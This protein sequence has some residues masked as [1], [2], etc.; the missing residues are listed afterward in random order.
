M[1]SKQEI[2]GNDVVTIIGAGVVV[3]GKLESN[4]N[5]RIDGTIKGN[6]KAKGNVTV[7]ESGIIEGEVFANAV[8]VGG[9][10]IGVVNAD[11]KVVLESDSS[12]KGDL[13]TKVLEIQAGAKFDGSSKMSSAENKTVVVPHVDNR[14]AE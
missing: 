7:G 9:T 1:K 14:N 5:V 13:I 10:I 4:G 3:E 2:T 11:S 8:T 12:L 6:V